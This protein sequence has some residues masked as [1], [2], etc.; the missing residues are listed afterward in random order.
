VTAEWLGSGSFAVRTP[1]GTYPV[2]V[3]RRPLY[4]PQRRRIMAED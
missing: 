2:T 3:S 1:A 4:D